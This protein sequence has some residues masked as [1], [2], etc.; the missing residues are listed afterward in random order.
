MST[1]EDS[2]ALIRRLDAV[3]AQPG[4]AAMRARSYD[5]LRL[6]PGAAVAD[7]GCGAGR[8]VA[9]LA[10]R[11]HR[12]VGLDPDDAMVATARVRWPELD[13]RAG[14]AEALPLADAAVAGYRADKVLHEVADTGSAMAEARRV[15]RPGGRIVLLGQDWDGILIDSDHPDLTR[16]IVHARAD[17][18]TN[19]RSARG[20]RNILLD[21]GFHEVTVEAIL[22]VYTGTVMLPMLT[23]LVAAARSRGVADDAALDDWRAEQGRRAEQDRFFAAVPVFLASA[24]R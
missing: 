16:A 15:L 7:V 5:L 4:A 13:F 20:Y 8:A 1:T 2:V 12:P 6:P 24:T 21:S 23:G 14:R 22:T 19:P 11:G 3:E 9:E 17:G 18:I 10:E